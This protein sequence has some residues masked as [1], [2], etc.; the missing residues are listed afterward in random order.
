MGR[1]RDFRGGGKGRG[2]HA[3]ESDASASPSD[4]P[5]SRLFGGET[6]PDQGATVTAI[7]NASA[8]LSVVLQGTWPLVILGRA[9]SRA[10]RTAAD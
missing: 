5:S 8:A 7:V 9:A 6:M 4:R 3:D 1:G 2:Y 10:Y